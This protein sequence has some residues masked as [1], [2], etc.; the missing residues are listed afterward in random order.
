ML[1]RTSLPALLGGAL[2]IAS[3]TARA[4][5]PP[6]AQQPAPAP[7]PPAA[8]ATPV[9]HTC[10]PDV[11]ERE[12]LMTL[13]VATFDRSDT[14]WRLYAGAKCYSQAAE[15]IEGY[16]DSRAALRAD[17]QS[18]LRYHAGQMLADANRADDAVSELRVV[19][20]LEPQR[21]HPDMG[22]T[23]YIRGFIGFL[24]QDRPALDKAVLELD[25][26]AKGETGKLQAGDQINLNALHGLQR[27]YGKDYAFAYSSADCRDFD[28]VDRLNQVFDKP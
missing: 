12:R 21:P 4:A 1:F 11:P 5:A 27:C 23:Q 15:L 26:Y 16:L 17:D 6:P 19:L 7:T 9:L 14:G 13:D 22:W 18:I 25:L 24:M 10:M 28:E 20:A 2:L 8:S 3:A